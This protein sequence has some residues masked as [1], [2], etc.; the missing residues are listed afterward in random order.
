LTSRRRCAPFPIALQQHPKKCTISKQAQTPEAMK[1][2][3]AKGCWDAHAGEGRRS[4][5]KNEQS[6]HGHQRSVQS[7]DLNTTENAARTNLIVRWSIHRKT[8]TGC[9]SQQVSG[10]T[11][12]K[13]MHV[14]S[15]R[16]R[17]AWHVRSSSVSRKLSQAHAQLR[18]EVAA[19]RLGT[20][21]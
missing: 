6:P 13:E 5:C 2:F 19:R 20:S 16:W 10:S 3:A 21:Q 9:A 12:D 14:M 15:H 7:Q 1:A 11:R 18:Q 8:H 4:C 17:H